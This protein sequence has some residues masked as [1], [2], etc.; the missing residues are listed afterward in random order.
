MDTVQ[1]ENLSVN[2]VSSSLALSP[3]LEPYI[4]IGDKEPSYDGTVYIHDEPNK[5]KENLKLVKVQVKG[6]ECEDFSNEKIKYSI[7]I[8][9]LNN[10]RN[11]GG[12]ILFV[13]Y[14]NTDGESKIYYNALAP[15]KLDII[16]KNTDN[17]EYKSI[18]LTEFPS[19][20]FEKADV[21]LNFW[22]DSHMQTSF[23]GTE[24]P[25]LEELEK[26]GGL[27]EISIHTS[28]FNR[29]KSAKAAIYNNEIYLYALVT[30]S[31]IPQPIPAIPMHL[32]TSHDINVP[33]SVGGKVLYTKFKRI[34]NKEY[35]T[36]R[37]GES[38]HIR[39]AKPS[40]GKNAETEI[41][42]TSS[43]MLRTRAKDLEF[44]LGF[45]NEGVFKIGDAELPFDFANADFSKFNVEEQS[46]QLERLK[47]AIKA[48]DA[49]GY[50]GDIN[51]DEL[52]AESEHNLDHI[53]DAFV[54]C[55]PI[56]G[57]RKDLPPVVVMRI[58]KVK[59]L[60][61]PKALDKEGTYELVDFGDTEVSY[62]VED[63]EG[64][65][66]QVSQYSI[67]N[68]ENMLSLSNIRFER[69][70]PSFQ[71]MPYHPETYGR[72]TLFLLE[73]I[74][75]YD[76]SMDKRKD[77]LR[78]AEDFANWIAAAPPDKMD[79][80]TARLNVLQIVK[81]NREFNQHEIFELIKISES[82]DSRED[83]KTAACLLLGNQAE[84]EKHFSMLPPDSKD[85]FK[86]FPIYRFWEKHSEELDQ[87]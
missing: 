45:V 63:T 54:D 49:L 30:G 67:L 9:H 35:L 2:T 51:L 68:A 26:S 27:K 73:L 83:S 48:L 78:L 29:E 66:W 18:E 1:I 4:A 55:L 79:A 12:A 32:T 57:L 34:E 13:V 14:V 76:M 15:L 59:F 43:P 39:F 10:Y 62:V 52:D 36:A 82:E 23:S 60:L 42:Y 80:Q 81:R 37:I 28:T 25:S 74:K 50:S 86:R 7:E 6:R 58:G 3:Y 56:T 71:N 61:C 65:R 31:S 77:I 75:A 69:L 72:A 46:E 19:D 8:A 20:P 84:A 53:I 87:R 41:K 33:I 70:L 11:N 16:L 5:K 24:L 85:E 44:M 22:N 38:F 21:F 40:V 47:K 64:N 17:Q